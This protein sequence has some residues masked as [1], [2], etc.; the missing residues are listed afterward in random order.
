M[1]ETPEFGEGPGPAGVSLEELPSEESRVL[2]GRCE[3]ISGDT[4]YLQSDKIRLLELLK[5][6]DFILRTMGASCNSLN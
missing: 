3:N 4:I 6:L 2:K 5:H 1:K